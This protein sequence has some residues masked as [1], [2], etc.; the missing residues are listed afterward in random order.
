MPCAASPQ[1]IHGRHACR[2][3][4]RYLHAGGGTAWQRQGLEHRCHC[5]ADGCYSM[6]VGA[7]TCASN[8]PPPRSPPPSLPPATTSPPFCPPPLALS[9]TQ[10]HSSQLFPW[11]HASRP[12]TANTLHPCACPTSGVSWALLG[13]APRSPACGAARRLHCIRQL[14]WKRAST[15]GTSPITH[16]HVHAPTSPPLARA[17]HASHPLPLSSP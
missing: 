9:T 8:L 5:D 15:R 1:L 13:L 6:R 14:R 2:I 17:P 12:N 4:R 10:A 7:P 11:W 16:V 3:H